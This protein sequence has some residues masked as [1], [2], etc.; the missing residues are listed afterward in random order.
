MAFQA[1][2]LDFVI[3]LYNEGPSLCG[4][5]DSLLA[6]AASLPHEL[7]FLYV[8][9]GSQDDTGKILAE[10]ARADARVQPITLSRNFGHQ[11]ALSAG[12]AAASGDAVVMMDGDGE[13]PPALV[14]EMVRLYEAGYDV[15][16][17]QR[18]EAGRGLGFKRASGAAFYWLINRLGETHIA[19]GA[20]DFRLLSRDAVSALR[21][22]R[23]YH[24]FYRGLVEWIGF[25]SVI[26]PYTPAPRLAGRSKYSLLKML[27]LAEDGLF[28]FSLAPLRLALVIGVLFLVI[29]TV[30]IVYVLSLWARGAERS[31]VPGWSS[32]MIMLTMSSAIS[33]ILLGILGFY[34]GMIFEEVKRRP[35]YVV[36][37]EAQG[38]GE[39]SRA[40]IAFPDAHSG[41]DSGFR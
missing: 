25:R 28:S 33:M 3:P 20:A 4:F 11:A 1:M 13:H 8:D 12:I 39:R 41:N 16:Q 19:E 37:P 15:V 5:H 26:L 23:E 38:T 2:R 31:L 22:L 17:T 18:H 21:Q 6:A 29:L 27:R 32:L 35:V 9:D 30:E 10:L 40:H 24:R 7:R 34:V 14:P 36:R